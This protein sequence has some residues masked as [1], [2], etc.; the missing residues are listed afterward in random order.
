MV[1]LRWIKSFDESKSPSYELEHKEEG[2]E[3]DNSK[4]RCFRKLENGGIENPSL[5][6]IDGLYGTKP[7]NNEAYEYANDRT[8]DAKNSLG[9]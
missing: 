4:K 2:A 7:K 9:L 1:L 3:R 6:V 8:E 5:K